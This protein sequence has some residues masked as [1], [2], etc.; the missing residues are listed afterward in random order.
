MDLYLLRDINKNNSLL[1]NML[2]SAKTN[3][4]NMNRTK[5]PQKTSSLLNS[6]SKQLKKEGGKF[7][8]GPR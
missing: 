3:G 6:V 7:D 1:I 4:L 5:T 2:F 8:T